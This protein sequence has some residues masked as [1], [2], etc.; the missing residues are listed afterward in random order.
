MLKLIFLNG[1]NSK[2]IN[3][4]MRPFNK[5]F[6]FLSRIL[7]SIKTK[8]GSRKDN[9]LYASKKFFFKAKFPKKITI[10]YTVINKII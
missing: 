4:N 3:N 8:A 10:K 2:I 1:K 9:K 6:I 5:K 7:L